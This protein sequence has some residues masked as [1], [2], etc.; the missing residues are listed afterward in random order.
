[1]AH[2]VIG[3][4]DVEVKLLR[5][6]IREELALEIYGSTHLRD[7]DLAD[8]KKAAMSNRVYRGEFESLPAEDFEPANVDAEMLASSYTHIRDALIAVAEEKAKFKTGWHSTMCDTMEL[9][10]LA[11]ATTAVVSAVNE[12]AKALQL[13]VQVSEGM[14]DM[15][16]R[17]QF[18]GVRGRMP[19]RKITQNVAVSATVPIRACQDAIMKWFSIYSKISRVK[20]FLCLGR[21]VENFATALKKLELLLAA[22]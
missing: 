20:K 16:K 2:G 19:K 9:A 10:H 22:L 15:F 18:A 7:R 11:N 3:D 14:L 4:N 5:A 21:H 8:R 1:M 12:L 17:D 6:L 13:R